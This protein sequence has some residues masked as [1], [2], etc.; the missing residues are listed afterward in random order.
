MLAVNLKY[1]ACV[2]YRV[3]VCADKDNNQYLDREEVE[4]AMTDALLG[5]C[6]SAEDL[7]ICFA[8]MD[9]SGDGKVSEDE[10]V[11]VMMERYV[12]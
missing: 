9:V 4:S 12:S 1:G 7:D 11:S 5:Q 8:K 3:F 10:F 2:N 6:P